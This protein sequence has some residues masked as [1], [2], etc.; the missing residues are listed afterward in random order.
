MNAKLKTLLKHTLIVYFNENG[1]KV[2]QHKNGLLYKGKLYK[3]NEDTKSML[4]KEIKT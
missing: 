2:K 3:M 4:F 1:V